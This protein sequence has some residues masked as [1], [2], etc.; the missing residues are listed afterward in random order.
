MKSSSSWIN[1]YT[2]H[3]LPSKI[4]KADIKT[5]L[6]VSRKTGKIYELIW[7]SGD[8]DALIFAWWYGWSSR[9]FP[10]KLD[11]PYLILCINTSKRNCKDRIRKQS[12]YALCDDNS[13][14]WKDDKDMLHEG[15]HANNNLMGTSNLL[16]SVCR[17][18]Q[19]R[20]KLFDLLYMREER[21][22]KNGNYFEPSISFST[23]EAPEKNIQWVCSCLPNE[24]HLNKDDTVI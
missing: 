13:T 6:Y 9:R 20:L 22:L 8:E 2:I 11:Q 17:N 23:M 21:N 12:L 3:D 1:Q 4:K 24:K 18:C 7:C 14:W 5:H 10:R 19:N 16:N 15:K